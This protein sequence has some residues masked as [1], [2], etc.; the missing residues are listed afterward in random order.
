MAPQWLRAIG[1]LV[2]HGSRLPEPAWAFRHRMIVVFALVTSLAVTVFALS[3]GSKLGHALLEGAAPALL[4]VVAW[5]A[6]FGRRLRASLAS[7]S[8]MVAAAMAVHTSGTIEAHFL[9]FIMVPI[10]ALYEDWTPL[11]AAALVV[12]AHHAALGALAPQRLYN[13]PAAHQDPLLWG[14]IHSAFFLA[15]CTTSILHWT[16][17]ERARAEEDVLLDRLASQ[18]LHDPLTGLANRTL[19]HERLRAARAASLQRSEPLLVLSV[20]IDGFKPVNDSYGHAAGDALLQELARRIQACSRAG[21]TAARAGGDEFILVLPGSGGNVA[22]GIARRIMKAVAVP[23]QLA[24]TVLHMTASVGVALG[25]GSETIE[26]LLEWADRAMYEAKH[27]G[28]G[29]YVVYDGLRNS[30]TD[31]TLTVQPV[32]ARSWAAYTRTLRLEIAAAKGQGRLPQQTRG[33]ETARRTLESL[34]AAIDQLPSTPDQVG[35]LL[36]ERTALQEFVFHH[37]LVQQW[38][39]ALTRQGILN[40]PRPAEATAFWDGLSRTVTDPAPVVGAGSVTGTIA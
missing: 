37:E 40:V 11:G 2:P 36:P 29:R 22:A 27:A 26:D 6:P 18:A 20:D 13:H 23:V 16:I 12:F 25:S 10:V 3:Q 5:K 7:V 34:L 33:P 38:T 1:S 21:D 24:G 39:D 9:F 31:C 28:R 15:I 14:I 35:M 32:H 4:S 8:L 17:H 19:L 30:A